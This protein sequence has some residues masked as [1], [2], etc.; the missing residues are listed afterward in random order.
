MSLA[1][2]A[3]DAGKERRGGNGKGGI[4]KEK[5]REREVERREADGGGSA[6]PRGSGYTQSKH[7]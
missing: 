3:L 1:E 5:D 6:T 7:K 2:E 4:R